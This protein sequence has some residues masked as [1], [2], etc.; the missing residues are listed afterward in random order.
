MTAASRLAL[1]AV[2]ALSGCAPALRPVP[3]A[4]VVTP[5]LAWRT[6]LPGTAAIDQR[7]WASFGDP[8]LTAL[9]EAARANNNDVLVAAARIEEARGTEA[10]SRSLLFPTVEGGAN[11]AV[12]R[13]VSAFGKAQESVVAQPLARVSYELD[14][15]GKNRAGIDAARAGV[16]ASEAAREATLL[17]VSGATASGYVTLLALDARLDTLKRTLA[18]Q[19]KSVHYAQRRAEV[20]YT[21]QL[22]WRQA[23]AEYQSTAQLV[24]QV[25]AQ[26]ARQENA[27]SVLTG[28]LPGAIRRGGTLTSLTQPP[29]PAIVPSELLRRRPDIAAAEYQLAASDAQMRAARARFLPTIGISGSVGT[30]FSDLLKSPI[31]IWS[32]GGSVLAPIFDGGRLKG[33]LT[34]ATARRDQ[35]AFAYRGTVLTAFRE[36]EDRLATLARLR[37]QQ[38]ALDAQRVA[39][40]DALRHAR[41]RY[42]AGYSPYIE[43]VDAQRSLLGVEL[44]LVQLR[45]DRLNALIGLYQ[46]V[47]GAPPVAASR[48]I[49]SAGG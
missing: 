18:V 4:S 24:P 40:A 31:S 8:A 41:N 17:S 12:R 42:D 34:S 20:G 9:V 33:Q 46:A 13:E 49:A 14:L 28:A 48:P 32:L 7:W 35:A 5:P 43:Q 1:V 6:E 36:V 10:Q 11:A 16:A 44:S 37:D 27:L 21:S 3:D 2:L 15:F 23:Q 22:E 39:V 26:I 30:V 45:A 47:G 29:P 25:E 19:Q 38:A